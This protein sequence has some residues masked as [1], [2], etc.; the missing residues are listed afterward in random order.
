M[1][2]AFSL[3][4]TVALSACA[5]AGMGSTAQPLSTVPDASV[6]AAQSLNTAT[7]TWNVDTG[8]SNN[9]Y[10]LQALAFLPNSITINA[11]D[12]I[13]YRIASGT[14]GDAHT[15][16]FVP[17]GQRVPPPNDPHNVIPTG[18]HIVDGSKFVNS[19]IL[20]GGQT[21]ALTFA[22]AG[23]YTIYCL[24]HEPAMIMNVVVNPAGSARPHDASFYAHV[25]WTELWEDLGAA[26]QSVQSFPFANGGTTFAAGVDPGL[27]H[28]PPPDSTVLRFINTRDYS[29]LGAEGSITIKAGT[30]LTW[31]NLTSNEP[32]TITFG[33]AGSTDLPSIPPDP[34]VNVAPPGQI[35]TFDGSKIVNSGTILGFLP[36][37][38]NQ[39][40]LKF[41]KPGRYL[42]GCLYH[43]NS[44]M[45]GWVTVTP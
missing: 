41:T 36:P 20:F 16:A 9:F 25:A 3:L 38:H 12:S 22:K 24:F 23:K 4:C 27:V 7:F 1:R 21:F 18:G 14:G 42:Y 29:K 37:P 34:A 40:Q 33:T 44:R 5:G 45:I 15:V 6:R 2:K 43:D 26:A 30:V 35:T 31:V 19:G 11:G 32:H 10:A 28:F 8:G 13:V 17:A 39:F